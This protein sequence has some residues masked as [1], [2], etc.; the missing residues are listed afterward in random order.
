MPS[1]SARLVSFALGTLRLWRTYSSEQALRKAVEKISGKSLAQPTASPDLFYLS[2]WVCS[3][4]S[5]VLF[6]AARLQE[7]DSGGLLRS[8]PVRTARL[9]FNQP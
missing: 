9:D 4:D 3:V 6:R 7:G 5:A 1:V 2:A 8:F